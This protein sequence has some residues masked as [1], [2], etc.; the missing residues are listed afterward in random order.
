M[1]GPNIIVISSDQQRWDA[2]GSVSHYV[3]TPNLD[4]LAAR[5]T[6]FPNSY[7]ASPICV[8]SR[9]SM[10]TGLEVHQ[11]RC[12][13]SAEPYHG[14]FKS[15]HHALREAGYRTTSIGKLHFRSEEDDNGFSEEI[16][17]THII[18]GVGYPFVMLR[19]EAKKM[20]GIE[21]FIDSVGWGTSNY[22]LHDE[23][24]ADTTA[25][26]LTEHGDEHPWALFVSF[27]TPHHPLIVPERFRAAYPPDRVP[28]PAVYVAP[29]GI[30]PS[31][32]A[33]PAT[34][35]LESNLHYNQYFRDEAHVREQRTYY[36]ALTSFLDE[37]VGKVLDAVERTGHQEDT[38]IIFTSDHGEMLGDLGLW[39][40]SQMHDGS[41]RVP[42][43]VAGP[44]FPAGLRSRA[45]C[46]HV[47]IYPTVTQA[48]GL[49]PDP[50]RP[51]RAL[52]E[53]AAVRGADARSVIS[54]YHDYGSVTGSTMLRWGNW[55]YLYHPGYAPQL[56]DMAADPEEL[57]DLIAEGGHEDIAA[58]CDRE[59]RRHLDPD[60]A[61][62]D[63][64][65][66]Q[67]RRVEELGGREKIL[68]DAELPAVTPM[69]LGKT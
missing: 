8:P 68:S 44:D 56:F 2:L 4:R 34:A 12:W 16:M 25:R 13:S 21:D 51:G 6:S 50:N 32:T 20:D 60:Q 35:A 24:V 54:G 28:L 37:C 26:W 48:A 53:A 58:E 36:M 30:H 27:V 17:P 5:G 59:L 38:L 39:T 65:E 1:T 64:F 14:Q 22:T 31:V 47:D 61:S 11:T 19:P 62:A 23:T 18:G 49:D 41:V 66:D 42:L 43:I 3:D 67:R 7:C 69:N 55:K 33:H 10:A 63:A 52:Q 29:P 46:S 15:W 45:V 57:C 40:K 9:A